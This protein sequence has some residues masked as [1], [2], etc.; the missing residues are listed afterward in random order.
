MIN[1]I[2]WAKVK[3]LK[4]IKIRSKYNYIPLLPPSPSLNST[5]FKED[6]MLNDFHLQ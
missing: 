4:H 5:N 1:V 2:N 3:Q 6:G